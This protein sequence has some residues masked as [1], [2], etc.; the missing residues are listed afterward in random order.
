MS[1]LIQ[2]GRRDGSIPT[3][4]RARAVALALIGAMEG[5]AITLAGHA[6]HDELPASRAAAGILGLEAA[7][8]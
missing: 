8:R 7:V 4:P 6:P 5:T 2:V 1:R 3:G